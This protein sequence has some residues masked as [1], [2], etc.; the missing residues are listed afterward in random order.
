MAL[1]FI[2]DPATGDPVEVVMSIED[3]HGYLRSLDL[4]IP[5][6]RGPVIVPTGLP[7]YGDP[8]E[9][10]RRLRDGDD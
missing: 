5:R 4:P 10:Q 7:D 6:K 3:W 8:V 1:R 2:L 9:F